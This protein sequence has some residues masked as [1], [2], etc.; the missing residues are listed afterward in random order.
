MKP[1][2]G[3][4]TTAAAMLVAL[5]V[6]SAAFLVFRQEIAG[7]LRVVSSKIASAV[8]DAFPR[9]PGAAARRKTKIQQLYNARAEAVVAAIALE[10]EG[11]PEGRCPLV[12]PHAGTNSLIV[13]AFSE[14]FAR[15]IERIEELDARAP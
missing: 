2:R 6:L 13:Q 10:I 7:V 12:V 5:A 4:K 15:I 1:I 9:S 14:E 3:R 11:I 8:S